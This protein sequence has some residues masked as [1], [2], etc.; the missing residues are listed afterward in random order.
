M[1]FNGWQIANCSPTSPVATSDLDVFAVPTGVPADPS[2]WIEKTET[3]T[4]I[5][6]TMWV[7][8]GGAT[9]QFHQQVYERD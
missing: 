8:M 1:P 6:V 7:H 9:Y 4:E 3:E 2:F 5:T